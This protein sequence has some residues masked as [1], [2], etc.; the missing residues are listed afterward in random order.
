MQYQ[1]FPCKTGADA[2]YL[3]LSS[4]LGGHG[5]FWQPQ[6]EFFQK[7][8]HVFIYDQ[9]G[10]HADSPLLKYDYTMEDLALQLFNFIQEAGIEKFHFIG[11]ALGGFIGAELAR[12][13]RYTDISIL[14][15]TILN[16]WE[17]LDPHTQ[18]CFQTRMTLLKHVGVQ[19]YVEAQ[20]LFLYPPAWISKNMDELKKQEQKQ[21]QNFLPVSNVFSRLKALMEF[22][23][24]DE[25]LM[26]LKKI[27]V[28]LIANKDDFLVP[29]HQ[30]Q[31]LANTIPN[32]VLHLLERGGH[33]ATV[34]ET[35]AMNQLMLSLIQSQTHLSHSVAI[36]A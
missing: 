3:V 27:P 25:N 21:I 8:F 14:S 29:Y 19:A 13:I 9:E 11:H 20:A 7:H 23:L 22:E 35:E 33:A 12:I 15:L 34:T 10:C 26:V 5:A 32:A 17:S 2:E 16:G 36:S 28:Y 6:I 18:K 1:I 30:S 4:G 31:A 24:F